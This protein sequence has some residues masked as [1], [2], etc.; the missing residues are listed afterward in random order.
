MMS[1]HPK[2]NRAAGWICFV[3]VAAAAAVLFVVPAFVTFL[4]SFQNYSPPHGLFE[5]PWVGLDNYRRVF[6]SSA[7]PILLRNSLVQSLL[8]GLVPL[9]PAFLAGWA[10]A[11][12]RSRGLC[13]GLAGLL[14]LPAFLPGISY[15]ILLMGTLPVEVKT[16]AAWFPFLYLAAAGM[17]TFGFAAFLAAVSGWLAR[18]HQRSAFSGALAGTGIMA[19]AGLMNLFS[20]DTSLVTELYNPLVYEGADNLGTYTFRTGFQQA[21]FSSSSAAWM[22]RVL[23][24][25]LPAVLAC[26]LGS[27]LL[28]HY[29]ALPAR[30]ESRE[31]AN[32]G[33]FGWIFALLAVAAAIAVCAGSFG[34]AGAEGPLFSAVA[35]S[36]LTAVLSAA[37]GVV[38]LAVSGYGMTAGFG[39]PALVLTAV[40]FLLAQ[41]TVGN[42]LI[43]RILGAVNTRLPVLAQNLL[44]PALP[45]ALA[46]L[47]VQACGGRIRV[48]GQFVRTAF[49]YLLVFGGLLFARAWGDSYGEMIYLTDSGR[50]G[51]STLARQYNQS[52]QP[53]SIFAALTALVPLMIGVLCAALFSA[54]QRK[55]AE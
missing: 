2:E 13:F 31:N 34:T 52:G 55:P 17:K 25:L 47:C 26:I 38:M 21:A 39:G 7:F 16:S 29:F 11:Q 1:A 12:V 22:I 32:A 5:S 30:S 10:A 20:P 6:E 14:L 15:C 44:S 51:I 37:A 3:L 43:V 4:L 8:G 53:G 24:Q 23:L 35:Q 54:L 33:V 27:L 9:V 40:M 48:P 36:L 46:F 19:A 50:L 18:E 45:L 41:N 28:K 42:F 49:P